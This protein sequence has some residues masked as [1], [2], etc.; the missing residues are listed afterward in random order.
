MLVRFERGDVRARFALFV[1]VDGVGMEWEFLMMERLDWSH[2]STI[3]TSI[4]RELVRSW[5]VSQWI[6]GRMRKVP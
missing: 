2:M 6:D 5:L 3:I 4:N 1:G